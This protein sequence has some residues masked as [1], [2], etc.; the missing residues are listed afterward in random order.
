MKIDQ[1]QFVTNEPTPKTLKLGDTEYTVGIK[2]IAFGDMEKIG[3]STVALIS[4]AV[5]FDDGQTLTIEQ[6]ERLDVATA[7]A[8]LTLINEVNGPKA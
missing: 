6:A 3:A 8:L 4:N 7:A 2:Q 5:I 1:L